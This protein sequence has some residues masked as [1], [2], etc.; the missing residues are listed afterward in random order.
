MSTAV[1]PSVIEKVFDQHPGAIKPFQLW[2][3]QE[4]GEIRKAQ[5]TNGGYYYWQHLIWKKIQ[6]TEEVVT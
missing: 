6:I 4:R 5:L 2:M 1:E 3:Y